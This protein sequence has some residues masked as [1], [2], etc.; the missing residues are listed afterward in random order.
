MTGLESR[1]PGGE[2]S[3]G[4][5]QVAD[6]VQKLVAP[7]LVREM[8]LQIV[9]VAVLAD[10]DP[11]FS[12]KAGDPVE[13]LA[14][15]RMLDDHD[16][17]VDVA[18]LD[19]VV[20]EEVLQ[21]VEED[22]RPARGDLGGVVHGW[23]PGGLLDAEDAGA[24]VDGDFIRAGVGRL[25]AHEGARCRVGDL[26]RMV[27]GEHLP[28]SVLLLQPRA[29]E[30]L[31]IVAGAAVQDRDFQIVHLDEGVVHAQARQ[32]GHQVLHRRDGSL[33]FGKGRAPGR[34]RDIVGNG[35]DEGVFSQVGAAEN[36]S[37]PR[38]GRFQRHMRVLSG[39]EAFP[40]KAAFSAQCPL[41]AQC[42]KSDI[43]R[44]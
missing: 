42:H 4:E 14:G 6:Q 44:L 7:A 20:G 16:G 35:M 33:P 22:E 18:S 34:G 32:G 28:G 19:Q 15:D 12:E 23:I 21:F 40:L 43:C 27:Q 2:E 38:A 24:E 5:P 37:R 31:G 3:A 13:L 26:H 25:E 1:H 36:D 39:M 29:G 11:L 17:V 30:S 41:L 9:Q 8:Q 10:I